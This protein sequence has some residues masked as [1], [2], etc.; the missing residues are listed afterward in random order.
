MKLVALLFVASLFCNNLLSSVLSSENLCSAPECISSGNSDPSTAYLCKNCV[1][2][3]ISSGENLRKFRETQ[4][5]LKSTNGKMKMA[6]IYP[7]VL[8]IIFDELTLEQMIDN[9]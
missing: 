4:Q 2:K 8:A 1:A 3:V 9:P 6:H 7:D 5:K